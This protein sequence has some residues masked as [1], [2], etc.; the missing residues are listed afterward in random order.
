MSNESVHAAHC[1]VSHGCK[2]ADPDCPVATGKISQ[3]HL[4]EFCNFEIEEEK[5]EELVLRSWGMWGVIKRWD[6]EWAQQKIKYKRLFVAPKQQLSM[7][8]HADRDEHWTVL[9][10]SGVLYTLRDGVEEFVCVLEKEEQYFIPKTMIH[11]I[12][13]VG[14]STLIIDEWQVGS[15]VSEDDIVRIDDYEKASKPIF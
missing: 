14:N 8:Y 5:F 12:R 3:N 2:Y 10:G 13:N 1:C 6:P 4:C 15:Q 9:E 7:Q 11:Q